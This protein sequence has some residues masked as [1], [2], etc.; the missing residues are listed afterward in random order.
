MLPILS[1]GFFLVLLRVNCFT[2]CRL[3]LTGM[4]NKKKKGFRRSHN[5]SPCTSPNIKCSGKRKQCTGSQMVSAL[6]AV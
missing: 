1:N 4:P 5:T 6:D 2:S 3:L